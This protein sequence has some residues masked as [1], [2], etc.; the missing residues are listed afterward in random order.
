VEGENQWTAR[1]HQVVCLVSMS[2][3]EATI[4]R[5]ALRLLFT[6]SGHACVT[7]RYPRTQDVGGSLA[8]AR[9]RANRKTDLVPISRCR[10][11]QGPC[12][13]ILELDE[14]TFWAV[15]LTPDS[16]SALSESL[17][18]VFRGKLVERGNPSASVG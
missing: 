6:N 13:G 12:V 15:P 1:C 8:T 16:P 4:A 11:L 7:T 14:P 2:G 3:R 10:A 18:E 5:L 9:S 17:G